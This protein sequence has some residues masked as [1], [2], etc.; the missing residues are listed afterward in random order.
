[1]SNARLRLSGGDR[2]P[3]VSKLSKLNFC[4]ESVYVD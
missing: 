1:M 4:E 2:E 3:Y